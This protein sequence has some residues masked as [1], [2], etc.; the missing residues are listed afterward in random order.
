MRNVAVIPT[1][2]D[3]AR[4][5]Q[6]PLAPRCPFTAL[7]ASLRVG[8]PPQKSNALGRRKL[9]LEGRLEA[10]PFTAH[11]PRP[12]TSVD[13]IASE[14]RPPESEGTLTQQSRKLL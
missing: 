2:P 11:K 3:A 10:C 7:I 12:G 13:R 8:H 14:F 9:R 5:S 1:V 6:G 4:A